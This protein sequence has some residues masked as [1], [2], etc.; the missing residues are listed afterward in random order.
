M[1]DHACAWSANV[2]GHYEALVQGWTKAGQDHLTSPSRATRQPYLSEASMQKVQ[3]RK[4]LRQ[5]FSRAHAELRRRL[6]LI[7]FAGLLHYR[8]GSIFA[9]EAVHQANSWLR[10]VYQDIAIGSRRLDQLGRDLRASAKHDRGNYLQSLVQRVALADIKDPKHLFR[11]V[12]KAF[13]GAASKRRQSFIPLPAVE[14]PDGTLA[15]SP[16]HRQEAWRSH[17][18]ELEAGEAIDPAGY[19]A[20]F[21]EQ[22][23]AYQ[24]SVP[25][26]DIAAVPSLTGVECMI[27]ELRSGKACG[28]DGLTGELWR[29]DAVLSARLLLPVFT[30]AALAVQEPLEFR[31]G[32]LMPLA[33]QAAA[34]LQCS[35]FRAILLSNLPSKIYH[36]HVRGC[37]AEHLVPADLQAGTLPGVSTEAIALAAR[38]FQARAR[39]LG[40]HWALLYFDVKS[41]FYCVIRQLLVPVGDTDRALRALFHKLGVP[42]S[43]LSEL[44]SQLQRMA[45]IPALVSREHVCA[46]TPDVLQGTWFRLDRGAALTLTHQGTRPGDGLADILFA[47]SFS[48]YLRSAER[49]VAAAGLS[50][51]TPEVQGPEP[52]CTEGAPD[53]LSCGAWA[54]DFVH[55]HSQCSPQGLSG[56]VRDVVTCY[57]EQADSIGMTLGFARDKTA[58]V[59]P[60]ASLRQDSSWCPHQTNDGPCLMGRSAISGREFALPLVE[61]YKHLGGITTVTGTPAPEISY[62]SSQAWNTIRPFRHRLFSADN[63]A[64]ATR[65]LMLRSLAMSRFVFGSAI[66]PLHAAIHFR[67]WAQAYVALWRS[68]HRRRKGEHH[69]HSYATLADAAAPSPPLALA[70]ARAALLR[71]VVHR[72]PATL[73]RLLWAHW[74]CDPGASWLGAISADIQHAC[75]YVWD[76]DL[77]WW[78]AQGQTPSPSPSAIEEPEASA[79]R[80]FVCHH[81]FATFPMRKHLW[82]H[83]A[84]A[85][86]EI[87]PTRLLAHS[88]TCQ[89]CLKHFGSVERLQYHLKQH[90]DCLLR[91]AWLLPPLTRAELAEV[92]APFKLAKKGLRKGNWQQFSAVDTAMQ[93]YGPPALTAH[94]IAAEIGDDITLDVLG[95]LYHP[96]PAFVLSV[97]NYVAAKSTEGRRNTA[98]RFWDQRPRFTFACSRI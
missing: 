37:L 35:K 38:T 16:D 95:R 64:L 52:W 28:P 53:N 1:Q 88:S 60:L 4:Q 17:F 15:C 92:E 85:H 66:L 75:Q 6:L 33:K 9:P 19:P 89:A 59:V 97:E 57:V 20:L 25:V 67:S 56:A 73:K 83:L 43:A 54:D 93:S 26:F 30:K 8:Q 74:E 39:K 27:R 96:D 24:H 50:T 29:A 32:C 94:E 79:D 69:Q 63:I 91:T 90:G 7:G 58:A 45:T 5:H 18:S 3:V 77:R 70:L 98:S 40:Q 76:S 11:A 72:G 68:L 23:L 71:Q 48:A 42:A 2:D 31:G 22:R 55:M 36:K 12:R 14:L 49:A 21:R 41:A 86:D 62:R 51:A 81:C 87:T 44:A 46:V 47:F 82:V 61:A 10:D 78:K 65:R 84:R 80:P 34:T 13:P